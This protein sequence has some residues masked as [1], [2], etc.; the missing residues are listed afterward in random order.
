M[1]SAAYFVITY[2]NPIVPA[3]HIVTRLSISFPLLAHHAPASSFHQLTRLSSLSRSLLITTLLFVLPDLFT[4][5]LA[6]RFGSSRFVPARYRV[7]YKTVSR[8]SSS[9]PTSRH[10]CRSVSFMIVRLSP[11]THKVWLV[12][13]YAMTFPH[14]SLFATRRPPKNKGRFVYF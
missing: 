9:S 2:P 12:Y 10:R 7:R 14:P 5:T 13:G 8:L 4:A 6:R 3:P 1:S 11:S